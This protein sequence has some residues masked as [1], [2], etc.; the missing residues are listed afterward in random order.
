MIQPT[1][2]PFTPV[3]A[4]LSAA[5]PFTGPETLERRQGRCFRARIGSNE[6]SFG[7][8]PA[9]LAAMHEAIE[10]IYWYNDLEGHDLRC[11]L[12]EYHGVNSDEICLGAGID[13]LLGLVV[14]LVTM[15]STP[16]V[17]SHGAYPTFNYH[18]EGCGGALE[19]VPY[20]DDHADLEA[21]AERARIT[22]APL[23][24]CANPDNPMGTWHDAATIQR[25]ITDLPDHALVILDEAYIEFAPPETVLPMDVADHRVLRMR[26][27]SKAHAMAGARIGYTVAHRDLIAAINKIRNHFSVNR[28]A[29]AGALASLRDTAYLRTIIERVAQGRRTYYRLAESLGLDWIESATNFVAI[30]MGSAMRAHSLL[31]ALQNEDIFVRMPKVAPLHRCI[32]VSV[33]DEKEQSLFADAFTR[34]VQ[35]GQ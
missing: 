6:N 32:R 21:M 13:E 26:T 24:Y 22:R 28:I 10:R 5:A 14:R 19:A 4:G 1:D 8:S 25:F 9:A 15:P 27:F 33:G 18:V 20:R 11:A 31:T 35:N 3:I 17:T 2:L 29:Q 7:P 23:I 34:L 16:V 30:D 12:A